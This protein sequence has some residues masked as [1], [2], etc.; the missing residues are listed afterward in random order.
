MSLK[1]IKNKVKPSEIRVICG[2]VAAEQFAFVQAD[3]AGDDFFHDLGTAGVYAG[4]A[5]IGKHVGNTVF[6]HVA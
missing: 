1:F 6:A 2:L 3:A 5:G 4:H